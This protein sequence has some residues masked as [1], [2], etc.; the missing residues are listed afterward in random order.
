M[1]TFVGLFAGGA[2]ALVI[3]KILAALLFPFLGMFIGLLVTGVKL[4]LLAGVAYFVYSLVFK[5]R[6]EESDA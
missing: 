1:R 6:K 2:I 4:V 5:R 3:F